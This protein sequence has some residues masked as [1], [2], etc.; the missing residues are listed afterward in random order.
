MSLN[1]VMHG[2]A[3]STSPEIYIDV[4]WYGFVIHIGS[5][6]FGSSGILV[7]DVLWKVVVE[8]VDTLKLL[9]FFIGVWKLAVF[10]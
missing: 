6:A 3:I 4:Y 9:Q 2:L 5:H 8:N 1:L 10:G 7:G